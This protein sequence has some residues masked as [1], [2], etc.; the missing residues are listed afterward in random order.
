MVHKP[1]RFILPIT[2]FTIFHDIVRYLSI[3]HS[4][5]TSII[6]R[7]TPTRPRAARSHLELQ[8][9]RFA[10]NSVC[11]RV[12]NEILP[13]ISSV[14]MLPRSNYNFFYLIKYLNRKEVIRVFWSSKEIRSMLARLMSICL[15]TGKALKMKPGDQIWVDWGKRDLSWLITGE[16]IIDRS[17][18]LS[19]P[20][21]LLLDDG[22]GASQ[23]FTQWDH[24][25][26]CS[27]RWVLSSSLIKRESLWLNYLLLV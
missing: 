12:P 2:W 8:D 1:R 16:Y 11:P 25:L 13:L 6:V 15:M 4:N 7:F 14:S 18:Q 19:S 27:L 26:R 23:V 20:V 10:R 5:L 21:I 3:A 17:Y 24:L 22:P 9:S